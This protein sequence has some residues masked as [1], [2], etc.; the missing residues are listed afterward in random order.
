MA[1]IRLTYWNYVSLLK[2]PEL[3]VLAHFNIYDLG[4]AEMTNIL[5]CLVP[6]VTAFNQI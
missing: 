3:D 2:K 4:K 1:D 5:T 6:S